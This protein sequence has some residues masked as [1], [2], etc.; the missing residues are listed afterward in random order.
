M[1]TDVV[2][3]QVSTYRMASHRA[4]LIDTPGSP[5]LKL[6][7]IQDRSFAASATS[8]RCKQLQQATQAN[9][10]SLAV[11][12]QQEHHGATSRA[13]REHERRFEGTSEHLNPSQTNTN[14]A[15]SGGM[16]YE[17]FI[18]VFYVAS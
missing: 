14:E 18:I 16:L 12:P 11:D 13:I 1:L 6:V 5:G 3:L 4:G 10:Q 7:I 15:N 9:Q 17:Y 2:K 8:S